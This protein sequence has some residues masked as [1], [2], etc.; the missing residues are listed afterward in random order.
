MRAWR[1]E[2]AA[3]GGVKR[4]AAHEDNAQGF[5][6]RAVCR[7][8]I[9]FE[10]TPAVLITHLS[11]IFPSHISSTIL[12]LPHNPFPLTRRPHPIDHIRPPSRNHAHLKKRPCSSPPPS[13]DPHSPDLPPLTTTVQINREHKKADAAGTRAPVKANGNPVKAP[14]PMSKVR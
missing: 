3:V 5:F 4:I 11:S 1:R 14:T 7:N 2:L 9:C 6:V 13:I 12:G 8:L 10:F